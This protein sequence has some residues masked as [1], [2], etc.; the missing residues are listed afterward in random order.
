MK[1]AAF[2]L[3][4][5]QRGG[6]EESA[7]RTAVTGGSPDTSNTSDGTTANMMKIRE[8][9]DLFEHGVPVRDRKYH[10]RSYPKC[11]VG[12]EAVSFMV[13]AGMATSREEA[14]KLGLTLCNEFNLFE[15]VCREHEFKDG[16]Y[17]YRFIGKRKR[18]V[19]MIDECAATLAL[20]EALMG[21]DDDDG[22]EQSTTSTTSIEDDDLHDLKE[23]GKALEAGVEVKNRKW[24]LRTYSDCFIG[25][26]AVTFLIINGYVRTRPDAVKLGRR[27]AS[28]LNLFQHVTGDHLLQDDFLYYRFTT[29][30]ERIKWQAPQKEMTLEEK[31]KAFE[32]GAS[33][34]VKT[35]RYH[36]RAYPNTFVGT[37]AVTY[38][39]R[40]GLADSRIAAVELGRDLAKQGNLFRQ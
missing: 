25:A 9:M 27:V 15:H 17:F 31:A 13:K 1:Q 34:I 14:V 35:H 11:F 36:L 38:M 24:H 37:Q 23:I 2:R 5:R 4:R 6:G 16:Y 18:F 39:V 3:S 8:I 12:K 19:P 7:D 32:V 30:E 20:N 26:D 28:S 29:K 40:C 10:A 22:D 33:G 21:M